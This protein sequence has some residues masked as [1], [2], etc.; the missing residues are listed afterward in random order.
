MIRRSE[1]Q[2]A[3]RLAAL[4]AFQHSIGFK[5]R[6]P[7]LLA[8]ALTHRSRLNEDSTING[9]N[10]RLEFL[11]DAVLGLVAAAELFTKLGDR[12]EGDLARIKSIVVSE[13]TLAGIALA[14]GLDSLLLIGKGEEL[15]GGRRKKALLA[16]ALEALFGAAY[17]DA[18]FEKTRPLLLKY[19]IPE[20][21]KVLTDR[22]R[23]DYKTLIQEYAQ[24]WHKT[25]PEYSLQAKSGPDHDRTYSI[26]CSLLDTAYGPADGKTKKEAEQQAAALAWQAIMTAGGVEAARLQEIKKL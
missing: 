16:D 22:H 13:D 9:N 23:R 8:R 21:E 14:I 5:F 15:S 10:E 18:G 25:Q 20:I 6:N 17:I 4:V 24:K 11:G 19:L 12:A 1:P 26:T 7:T 3:D 2:E